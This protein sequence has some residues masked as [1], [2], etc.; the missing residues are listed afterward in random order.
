[1]LAGERD[2]KEVTHSMLRSMME[3]VAAGEGALFTFCPNPAQLRV[4]AWL[5]PLS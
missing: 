5:C 2:F 3:A 4:A 1:M